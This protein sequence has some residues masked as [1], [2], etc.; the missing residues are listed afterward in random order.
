LT[1]RSGRPRRSVS[2]AAVRRQILLFVEGERTEE[3]YL[4]DWHRRYRTHVRVTVAEEHGVPVTLVNLAVKAKAEAARDERRGRGAAWDEIWCVFDEDEHPNVPQ[5]IAKAEA[6]GIRVAVSS[7]CIELWFILHFEAQTAY[8]GRAAAQS[9]A[10][11]LL[12]CAKG[13]SDDALDSLAARYQDARTRARALDDKHS[14]DGS[15]PRSNPS[16]EVWKLIDQI[17]EDR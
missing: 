12:G 1:S 9:R 7:P 16:S 17:R 5:A 8:I 4:V 3:E 2:R 14:G 10:R 15:P 13:L 11:H 6:N